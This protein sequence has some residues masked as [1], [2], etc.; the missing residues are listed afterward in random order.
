MI[1]DLS[2]DRIRGDRILGNR[3]SGNRYFDKIIRWRWPMFAAA[4]L[5]G[6]LAWPLAQRLTLDRRLESMFRPDDPTLVDYRELKIAFGG[7]AVAMVVY[8]DPTAF[9]G[10]GLERNRILGETIK[11]IPGVQGILSP[12]IIT[13]TIQTVRPPSVSALFGSAS[14]E[15]AL[16]NPD[17]AFAKKFDE[18]FAGYTHTANHQYA[19]V[20][21]LLTPDHDPATIES[22][23]RTVQSLIDSG[24]EAALVGEPVLLH[25]G[26]TLIQRDGTRLAVWTIALLSIVLLASLRDVRFAVLSALTIFWTVLVT[27]AAV[28][29]LSIQLSIVSS[30]LTAIVTVIAVASVL[31]LGVRYRTARRR[32]LTNRAAT[33]ATLVSLSGPIFWTCATDAAGF[34]AL[35]FSRIRPVQDFGVMIAIA[36]TAVMLGIV[37][38]SPAIMSIETQRSG[39]SHSRSVLAHRT[40]RACMRLAMWFVGYRKAVGVTSIVLFGGL[41]FGVSKLETETSFLNNF[42]PESEIARAYDLVEREFGGAGVWD[43]ILDAPETLSQADMDSVRE[44]ETKLKAI[45]IDGARLSK[46]LSIADVDAVLADLPLLSIASPDVRLAGMR[47]AMPVISDALLTPANSGSAR[48]LRI[49]LR[50]NE[51]LPAET[52]NQLIERVRDIVGRHVLATNPSGASTPRVTGY[53]VLIASWIRQLVDDQW[54][55][56]I[57]SGILVWLLLVVAFRSLR[58]ATAALLPNL[59]P[60][61]FVLAVVGVLGDKINMGAAMIAAVSIGLSIDSSVHFLAS[62]QKRR[63]RGHDATTSAVHATGAISLPVIAATLALVVGFSVLGTSEFVPTATFGVLIAAT[64]SVGTVVNLTLLP[65]MVRL[66]DQKSRGN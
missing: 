1:K 28:V 8:H 44:L 59:L 24:T 16:T 2:D 49:M 19:S 12:A 62:Y 54:R 4:A 48:R 5:I 30:I 66:F 21:A 51:Q 20:V 65:A 40:R 47:L 34:A 35:L 6:I 46:V 60:V 25:D 27:R 45:E 41:L 29:L 31:H 9:T 42:R 36:A 61:F 33:F 32:G 26:F 50:S 55:C 18:I 58:L 7:N 10:D 14:S 37:L 22:L 13:R 3:V 57:A 15:P 11:N 38:F 17:D 53:Y 43:V 64:L 23:R 56:L 52:K 63:Q 39:V